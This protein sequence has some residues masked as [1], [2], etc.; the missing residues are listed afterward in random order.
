MDRAHKELLIMS[1]NFIGISPFLLEQHF[2][3]FSLPT[4][5]MKKNIQ[6]NKTMTINFKGCP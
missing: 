3:L 1:I 6:T 4:L 5:R 2:M